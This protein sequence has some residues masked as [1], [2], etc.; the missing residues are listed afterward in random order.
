MFLISS[1]ASFRDDDRFAPGQSYYR[2]VMDGFAFHDAVA[3]QRDEM[4]EAL[5]DRVVLV[6]VHGYNNEI[7]DVMRAYRIVADHVQLRL[8]DHYDAVLAY[9]WPG[10]DAATDWI[11]AKRRAGI[12]GV[13]LAGELA[14][15]GGA[16][17]AIDVMSH[18][19]GGRVALS[20]LGQMPRGVVRYQYLLA[21][22]IDNECLEPSQKYH[23]AVGRLEAT[24]VMHS[25]RDGTLRFIYRFA[26]FDRA[27]GD[28]GPEDP[29]V[30]L[31]EMPSISVAN[32]KWV[33][34]SHGDYKSTPA[35]YTTIDHW[36]RGEIDEP[37]FT[38]S[39]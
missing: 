11:A 23:A 15:I 6:L 33:I 30:I 12:A 28:T 14:T 37:F 9:T 39:P 24:L 7:D 13:R 8:A 5:R 20:A 17:A 34:A 25:R 38:V 21:S 3:V 22:A 36:L 26:Q 19:L 2:A 4:L 31:R 27:L 29:G 35:I 16:A 18:S 32:C 1:R 10:G